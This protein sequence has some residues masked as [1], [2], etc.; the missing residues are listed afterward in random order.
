VPIC[1]IRGEKPPAVF[2]LNAEQPMAFIQQMP[3]KGILPQMAL[4]SQMGPGSSDARI[5]V[6]IC[7]IGG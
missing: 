4:I 2:N 1:V 6:P 3:G 7:V 5:F